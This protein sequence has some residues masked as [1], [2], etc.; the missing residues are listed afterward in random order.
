MPPAPTVRAGRGFDRITAAFN[1]IPEVPTAYPTRRSN[2]RVLV[3]A[4]LLLVLGIVFLLIMKSGP[5]ALNS[6]KHSSAEPVSA[7]DTVRPFEAASASVK[8]ASPVAAQASNNGTRPVQP[9]QTSVQPAVIAVIRGESLAAY[10]VQMERWSC[11]GDQCVGELRIPPTVEAG[12]KGDMSAAANIFD[13]LKKEM[14]QA[15]VDVSLQS[16][17]PGP[18]GLA[19]SFQFTPNAAIQGRYYTAG[20]IA[21]IRLESFQQGRQ[22]R[23]QDAPHH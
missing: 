10:Q 22:E 5:G 1:K 3:A 15:D 12:R 16:I 4:A 11:E 17:H 18:Q 21:A 2:L 23:G 6:E 13:S 9:W 8:V 7:H 20:E 19:A 14:A